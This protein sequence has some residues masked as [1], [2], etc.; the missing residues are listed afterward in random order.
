[1]KTTLLD[2]DRAQ[3]ADALSS[4]PKYRLDQLWEGVYRQFKPVQDIKNLPAALR[5][6][7]TASFPDALEEAARSVSDDGNTIK[8]LWHLTDGG[9][10]IET[11]LMYYSERA[12]VCV[13]TQA[14]CAMACG[15]CATGQAGFTRHLT[16]GEIVE[17]VVRAA[18]EAGRLGQ[19]IDNIVFMGMGEPL[20][21]EDNV[22][23]AVERIHGD[24]GISAR[25]LTVSTV[26]I[27]P[28]I[29]KLAEWPLPVNLAV[30]L[31]A[32]RNPLR[33]QLVPVNKRY[34][35]EELMNACRD[36]LTVK[37]RRITFEWALIDGVNDTP[38]DAE[39]L[40]LL[41]RS[42]H[43]GAHINLIPLNPTPG[44]PTKGSPKRKVHEFRDML[45]RHGANATVRN[46]RGTEIAAACGQL[47]AG[48]PVRISPKA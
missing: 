31:H 44:W 45:E 24:I 9:H 42:M 34:P 15:F 21:N 35:I 11:V 25:H 38:R 26:G 12:T 7:V 39:E 36:Y 8:F 14:G 48:Q 22:R 5:D 17:Q 32:A 16:T 18:R 41:A 10:P 30:S 33:D 20:A 37:N 29:K 47:A 2:L 6:E 1:M 43:P 46:N 40:A 13:S 23:A 19:R 3:L 27:I 4:H 28:G